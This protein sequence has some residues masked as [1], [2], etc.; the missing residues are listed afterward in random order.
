MVSETRISSRANLQNT[1][2]DHGIGLLIHPLDIPETLLLGLLIRSQDDGNDIELEP[3]TRAKGRAHVLESGGKTATDKLDKVVLF[4]V[5]NLLNNVL[6][7]QVL[8]LR[9]GLIKR[10]VLDGEIEEVGGVMD[11][12]GNNGSAI[13]GE[14]GRDTEEES[15][16][17]EF[18]SIEG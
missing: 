7:N 16:Y 14:D 12:E 3:E 8:I 6:G 9:H 11:G 18:M 13:I 10:N 2:S 4:I 15:L 5:L 17:D 1:L